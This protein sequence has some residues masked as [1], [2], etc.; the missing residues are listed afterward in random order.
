MNELKEIY[1]IEL[2][3]SEINVKAIEILLDKAIETNKILEKTTIKEQRI[4]ALKRIEALDYLF[5]LLGSKNEN[6]S[7]ISC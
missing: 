1:D 2:S 7:N 6:E 5:T 4:E 3:Q